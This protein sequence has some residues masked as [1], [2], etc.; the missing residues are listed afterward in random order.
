[1]KPSQ[2]TGTLVEHLAELR[3]R[4]IIILT[5]NIAGAL[6]C[7][8][9]MATLIQLFINL[10]PGMNLVY[11][12]PSEL[13]MV[14]VKLALLCA[15]IICFVKKRTVLCIDIVFFR[16]Y[17][18]FGRRHILLLCSP[19][20]DSTVFQPDCPRGDHSHGVD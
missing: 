9:Y 16:P 2:K 8:Q 19:S 18:F 1:M 5:V 4:L 13:F 15:V 6:I 7:Y 10:N 14:Y 20:G 11:I 12:S 3:K 17:L